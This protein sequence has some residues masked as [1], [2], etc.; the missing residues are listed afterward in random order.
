MKLAA[1]PGEDAQTQ[2]FE[3]VATYVQTFNKMDFVKTEERDE[4]YMVL[5]GVLDILSDDTLQK[6][7]LLEQFEQLRDF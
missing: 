7:A 4:V 6:S 3:A 2:A 5:R 1:G